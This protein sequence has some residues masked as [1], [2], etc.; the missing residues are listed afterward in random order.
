MKLSAWLKDNI[1]EAYEPFLRALG[2]KEERDVKS[3]KFGFNQFKYKN[4]K[5]G[6]RYWS[7]L[8]NAVILLENGKNA[9]NNQ[10][11]SEGSYPTRSSLY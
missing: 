3:P 8:S 1:P 4:T 2:D 6:K 7:E 10:R 5:E 9:N 11:G